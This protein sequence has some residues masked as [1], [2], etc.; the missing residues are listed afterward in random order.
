MMWTSCTTRSSTVDEL[1]TTLM[2]NAEVKTELKT[3]QS[4]ITENGEQP[5]LFIALELLASLGKLPVRSNG[6]II[7]LK[8]AQ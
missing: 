4:A 6:D 3:W 2:G 8:I 5:G 7:N 1:N